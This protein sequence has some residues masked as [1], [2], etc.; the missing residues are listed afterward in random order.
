MYI[1]YSPHGILT[2]L[3][4]AVAVI[5]LVHLFRARWDSNMPL[6]FYTSAVVLT[7]FTER[8]ISPNILLFGIAT[9]MLL[10]FEFMSVAVTRIVGTLT[11]LAVA[12]AAFML[13]EQ[14][15]SQG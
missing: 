10:R 13:A 7:Q 15:V 12:G 3:V 11:T 2:I 14:V 1:D 6:F 5:A 9:A 4:I 8:P